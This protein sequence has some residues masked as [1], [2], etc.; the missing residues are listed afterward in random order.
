MARTVRSRDPRG[1]PPTG[2]DPR[3]APSSCANNHGSAPGIWLEDDRGRWVAMLPGVPARDARHARRHPAADDSRARRRRPRGPLAHAAHHRTRRVADRRA[4]WQ[5][6]RGACPRR[7]SRICPNVDGV[8]LR[9]TVRGCPRPRP[10]GASTPRPTRLRARVRRR[11]SMARTTPTSPRSCSTSAAI[12]GSRSRVGE[13]CTG[14][15]LGERIT[16]IPG[17]SDVFLGGVI[18]YANADQ[19]GAA[20]RAVGELIDEHGAVSEAGGARDGHRRARAHRRRASASGSRASPVP[21]AARRRS[22]WA[23]SGSPRT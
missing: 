15:M 13:S 11:R 17:S 1:Q 2:D 8:D 5:A 23:R 3:R 19:D 20:R 12:A 16:R 9:L 4:A 21:T 10:T 7:R 6:S 22:R 18:A 14:G